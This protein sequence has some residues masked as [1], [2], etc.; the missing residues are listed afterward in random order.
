LFFHKALMLAPIA[1]WACAMP[2]SA[3]PVTTEALPVLRSLD[4]RVP[5]PQT[6]FTTAPLSFNATAAPPVT[7]TTTA[8]RF[9]AT[10]APPV[11]F[12]TTPL[13]FNA[14]SAP[15]ATFTTQPVTFTASPKGKP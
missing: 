10:S 1:L 3:A 11:T 2:I 12:T 5:P 9:N 4:L 15:P 7:F 13:S 14:A 6:T 8:L